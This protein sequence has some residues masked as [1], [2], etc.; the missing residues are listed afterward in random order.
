MLFLTWRC[1]QLDKLADQLAAIVEVSEQG[2]S[3][4]MR[5]AGELFNLIMALIAQGDNRL[6]LLFV[7]Q[8]LLDEEERRE[9]P[10]K[11]L[12]HSE[13]WLSIK[14]SMRYKKVNCGQV[15]HFAWDCPKPRVA[16]G[17]QRRL[18]AGGQWLYRKW[19]VCCYNRTEGMQTYWIIDSGA[20]P[21]MAFQR[22]VLYN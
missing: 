17:Q 8:H 2:S 6:T 13:Q 4:A 11:R 19:D 14:N 7:K 21:H 12:W 22:E 15:L 3:I 20:S 18:R 9:K 10:C 5:H 16:K 1:C